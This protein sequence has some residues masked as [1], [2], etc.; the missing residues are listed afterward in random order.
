[1]TKQWEQYNEKSM[2]LCIKYIKGTSLPTDVFDAGETRASKQKRSKTTSAVVEPKVYY[3]QEGSPWCVS[4]LNLHVYSL[5]FHQTMRVGQLQA[6]AAADPPLKKRRSVSST[7]PEAK[8][9]DAVVTV[10]GAE[11]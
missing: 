5:F 10:D 2:G 11:A 8:D 3:N 6:Q 1:M 4:I 7:A 9:E